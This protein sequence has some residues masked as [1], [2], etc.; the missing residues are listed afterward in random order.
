MIPIIIETCLTAN[1]I[2]A[3]K[4]LQ[5]DLETI[6]TSQVPVNC[7]VGAGLDLQSIIIP[8]IGKALAAG[9]RKLDRKNQP[10]I[11]RGIRRAVDLLEIGSFTFPSTPVQIFQNHTVRH[12]VVGF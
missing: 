2:A 9:Q 5:A 3:K 6:G 11:G 12:L 8:G 1:K 7:Q 10:V 4:P